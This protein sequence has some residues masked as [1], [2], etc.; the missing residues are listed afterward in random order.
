MS[1]K[2]ARVWTPDLVI[3]KGRAWFD[4]QEQQILATFDNNDGRPSLPSADAFARELGVTHAEVLS[5]DLRTIGAIDRTKA[6]RI[7][8]ERTRDRQ[9]QKA[10]RA[11]GGAT[12]RQDSLS[13]RKPW[14][15]LGMSRATYYRKV[16]AGEIRA[17]PSMLK[18][19]ARTRTVL[20]MIST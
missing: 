9:Y 1:V 15:A 13:A 14:Q 19:R 17:D 6:A 2:W 16:E 3:E 11:Q 10:V 20:R 4:E 18:R 8:E 7:V 5:H 12:A